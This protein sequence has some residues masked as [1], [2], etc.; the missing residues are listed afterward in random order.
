VV[1]VL[2]GRNGELARIGDWVAGRAA[3]TGPPAL[4]ISGEAGIG[5]TALLH[6]IATG[7]AVVRRAAASPWPATPFGVLA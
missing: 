5:K 3:G 6:A 2:V 7:P 1:G 4:L